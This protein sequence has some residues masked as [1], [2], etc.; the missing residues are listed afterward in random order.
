MGKIN[1]KTKL[2]KVAITGTKMYVMRP[3]RYN[4]IDA[5]E[6][7]KR[8]NTNT[9]I[10]YP[11]VKAALEGLGIV[12]REQLLNGHSLELGDLGY[13]RFSVKCKSVDNMADISASNVKVRRLLFIPKKE[14]HQM[15]KAITITN[16]KPKED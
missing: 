3:T 9:G 5:A 8:I 6:V 13:L 1:F 2:Q 7:A 14:V 12:M 11:V 15:M 4:R 10:A 16:T